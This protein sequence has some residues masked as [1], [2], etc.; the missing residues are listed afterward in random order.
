M[1]E[2]WLCPLVVCACHCKYYDEGS[3]YGHR[4]T[5]LET[6]WVPNALWQI[7][8][9]SNGLNMC[10]YAG[11]PPLQNGNAVKP[12][13]FTQIKPE[14]ELFSPVPTFILASDLCQ[15]P[16]FFFPAN[17]CPSHSQALLWHLLSSPHSSAV[18]A[19]GDRGGVWRPYAE[20]SHAERPGGGCK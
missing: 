11:A 15:K 17:P 7:C 12:K 14:S 2:K 10:P 19:Q 4:A 5:F 8:K 3:L 16:D 1:N 9:W 20:E 13:I 18:C 6:G